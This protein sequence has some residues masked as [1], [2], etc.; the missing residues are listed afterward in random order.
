MKEIVWILALALVVSA[1]WMDWRSARIPN[2]LTVPG[3]LIGLLTNTLITG[4]Q[5]AWMALGGAG[6][7]LAV[8]LPF[9]LLRGLG[10]GDW[11]L[12]GAMGAF[13]GIPQ[14]LLVLVGTAFLTGILGV[15]QITRM[16]LWRATLGN[17]W[18][19]ILM[20]LTFG[21]HACPDI[22]L[23][24]PGLLKLPF[25]TATAVAT[26]LCYGAIRI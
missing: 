12:M 26:V 5:G 9:V 6:L 10:A 11:K 7:A 17:L 13:L 25:G 24:N 23:D 4:K 16:R 21:R 2:W 3:L 8:L 1:G 14:V 15:I 19:L 18:G 20:F 22:T